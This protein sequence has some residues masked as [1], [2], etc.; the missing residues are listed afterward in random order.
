MNLE[1]I[2]FINLDKDQARRKLLETRLGQHYPEIPYERFSAISAESFSRYL[3]FFQHRLRDFLQPVDGIYPRPGTIGCFLSHY[4]L[5][6][7]IDTSWQASGPPDACYL[8][9]EDDCVFDAS[10]LPKVSQWID[11]SIP[12]DWS[13]A[14]HP[15][16]RTFWRDR[17]NKFFHHI[18]NARQLKWIYYW[19]AHFTIYRGSAI[20]KIVKQM[21]QG[22]IYCVD[23]WLRN[24]VSGA[25]GFRQHLNIKTSNLGGSNTNPLFA[26][27]ENQD[28]TA[29]FCRPRPIGDLLRQFKP[30][31]Y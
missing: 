25:Y 1:K 14:R 24:N 16:G 20:G 9:L 28:A 18:H 10:V 21:E 4:Q 15:R 31:K 13:L 2:Y 30:R 12:S 29:T 23:K 17:A 6:K 7:E 5:L 8:V 26:E 27:P 22:E 11:E 3:P 19:G